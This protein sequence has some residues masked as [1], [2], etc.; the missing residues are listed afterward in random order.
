MAAVSLILGGVAGF[1]LAILG[2]AFFGFTLGEAALCWIGG[3]A[4]IGFALILWNLLH[5][6]LHRPQMLQAAHPHG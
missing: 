1:V 2:Y 4:A 5:S 3:G 6:G